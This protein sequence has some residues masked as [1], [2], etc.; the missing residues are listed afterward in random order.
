MES[1]LLNKSAGRVNLAEVLGSPML[2]QH[3]DS[4]EA[5]GQFQRRKSKKRNSSPFKRPL[6]LPEIATPNGG[7]QRGSSFGAAP[8]SPSRSRSGLDFS[9]RVFGS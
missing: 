2:D 7:M 8:L 6:S 9:V 4:L 5:T 3:V 1:D